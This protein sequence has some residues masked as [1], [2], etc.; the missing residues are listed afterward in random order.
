MSLKHLLQSNLDIESI[1]ISSK[2]SNKQYT[3]HLKHR[4][5]SNNLSVYRILNFSESGIMKTGNTYCFMI[6]IKG[7]MHFN[8]RIL[9]SSLDSLQLAVI[10]PHLV[11]D[12]SFKEPQISYYIAIDKVTFDHQCEL[13]LGK[14]FTDLV[15]NGFVSMNS[16]SSKKTLMHLLEETLQKHAISDISDTE[17]AIEIQTT[18]I[19]S[20]HTSEQECEC[21]NYCNKIAL[22]VHAY[23]LTKRNIPLTL[24][25]ICEAHNANRN[26]VQRGFH[27]LYGM[28]AVEYHKLF[29]IH[30]VRKYLRKNGTVSTNLVD[31]IGM[32]GFYHSGR[33]SQYYKRTFGILPSKERRELK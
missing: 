8:G 27:E 33:F 29:R 12:F 21:L 32:Y 22:Q 15:H 3:N 5:L 14:R 4:R 24:D 17:K 20:L 23:L 11:A 18:L 31:I 1:D 9:D 25:Q 16:L 28:G 26:S 6:P 2:S 10:S 19:E 13:V 30:Q 7:E